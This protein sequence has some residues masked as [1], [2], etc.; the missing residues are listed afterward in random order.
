MDSN[1]NAKDNFRFCPVGF[2]Y[3]NSGYGMF[4]DNEATKY[5]LL[6]FMNSK[7]GYVTFKYTF[8]INGI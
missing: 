6:G 2:L 5:Y 4:C 7:S 3:S 1:W 8:T